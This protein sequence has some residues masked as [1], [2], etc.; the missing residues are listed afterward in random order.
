[1]AA[2]IRWPL[3][4]LLTAAL[5]ACTTPITTDPSTAKT[6]TLTT[7]AD[8]ATAPG[9][10]IEGPCAFVLPEGL[11]QGGNLTCGYLKVLE[12]RDDLASPEPRTIRLAVA[13]LHAKGDARRA[14]PVVYL[15]G[16]PGA[17]VLESLRF[18]LHS[19]FEAILQ[20]GRD[21]VLFDQRGVGRSRPALDCPEIVDLSRDLADRRIDGRAVTKEEVQDILVGAFV[22]CGRQLSQTSDLSAYNSV[23]SAGDVDELRQALGYERVNLWGGSYGTRLALEVMRLHPEGLRSVVL[24]AVYPPDIDLYTEAPANLDRALNKLFESC[25]TNPICSS[26]YP[27]LSRTFQET[28]ARLN[29]EPLESILM[30]GRGG[31]EYPAVMDGDAL[32]GLVFQLLYSTEAKLLIPELISDV[33]QNELAAAENL[34]SSLLA[35]ESLSSRG[36][37]F[38]VQC[39]EEV[40]YGSRGGAAGQVLRYPELAGTFAHGLLGEITYRVCERWGADEA[41]PSANESVISDLPTLIM[42]GEFDPITPP[43]WGHHVAMT[44]SHGYAYEYPGVGHGASATDGCPQQMML[45]FLDDPATQPDATCIDAMAP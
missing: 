44:L 26:N 45:A 16:G 6:P 23:T 7:V 29:T 2:A 14:D 30:D 11:E 12:R 15:S 41:P 10:F 39:A 36:M 43:E 8:D 24:D 1:M 18:G 3:I 38:S 35:Q 9:T 31:E 33:S 22:E 32:I 40:P 21:L 4:L 13:I 37:M 27:D 25:A 19:T 5:A 28:V 42:T 17:S 20:S 34:R